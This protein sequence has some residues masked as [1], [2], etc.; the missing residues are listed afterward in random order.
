MTSESS[1]EDVAQCLFVSG[2]LLSY[3]DSV[4][5]EGK[6]RMEDPG[7]IALARF[8]FMS[9]DPPERQVIQGASGAAVVVDLTERD[10]PTTDA[11]EGTFL[12]ERD[13]MDVDE[14]EA[15]IPPIFLLLDEN[16]VSSLLFMRE[17]CGSFVTRI[18]GP[19]PC[20]WTCT[21]SAVESA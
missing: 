10:W 13:G 20:D 9:K 8:L 18:E 12:V 3:A 6:T 15:A 16:S 7:V 2:S 1:S 19:C 17:E 14:E 11:T 4:L 5:V 21:E